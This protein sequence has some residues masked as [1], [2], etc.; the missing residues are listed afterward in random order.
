VISYNYF[1]DKHLVGFE[2]LK[3]KDVKSS[4]I[5]A[6]NV[7]LS[8]LAP[9]TRS[10]A[11]EILKPIF[12]LAIEDEI[13]L[14]TPIKVSHLPKR[15]QIEEKKIITQA[16]R[17]YKLVHK[18]IH[19]LFG[20][21]D[22][23]S[24]GDKK[25]KCHINDHHRALFLFGFHGRR[26]AETTSLQWEDID[27]E[28]NIYIVRGETSKV[29]TDMTFTLPEEV[30]NALNNFKDSRGDIFNVKKVYK[31]YEKIRLITGLEEYS[32]HWMRNLAVSALSSTGAS[33]TDLTAM[34][35]HQDSTTLKKYLSLQRDESTKRTNVLSSQI[36]SS[37]EN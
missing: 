27:F 26:R 21:N 20:S 32:Y 33:L 12:A 22:I 23:V 37:T 1:Y 2:S 4:H 3:I 10:K 17:K 31:H 30:K 7:S 13:I 14:R 28:N 5:T 34:L 35:G 25:I 11:Y 9:A 36:L 6:L 16:V 18:A 29:N 15:K 24:V 8:H 19:Q